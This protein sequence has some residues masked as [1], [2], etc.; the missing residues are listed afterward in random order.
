M[1]L[2]IPMS[3]TGERFRRAGHT[4]PKPLIE[5]EGKPIVQHVVESF[6]GV[7]DVVLVC[8]EAHLA[9]PAI[10][11]RT[12]LRD[13]VPH[14]RIASVAPHKLGPVHA[15]REACRT[16]GL[17]DPARPVI[18]N[19]CDFA[20]RWDFDHFVRFVRESACMGCI[21]CYTGFHPH[22]LRS[23]SYAY[24]DVERDASG[25]RT[26]WGR[27]IQEKRPFTLEPMEEYAS[28]GTYYFASAETMT[29]CMDA[30]VARDLRV[31]GE[32]YVSVAYTPL[33]EDSQPVAVYPLQ[34][35]MQ[36]G[37]PEDLD[38][39][40][41]WSRT[42]R[43]L[44]T[45]PLPHATHEGTTLIPMGGVG[46]RFAASTAV[47]KPLIDVAGVPM[48]ARALTDLP[49]APRQRF[50]L[51]PQL[52]SSEPLRAVLSEASRAPS[53]VTLAHGT[54]GQAPTCLAGLDGVDLDAPLTIGACDSGVLFDD[55]ALERALSDAKTDVWVYCARGYPGAARD[56]SAY[57]WVDADA[58]GRVRRV[59]V[60]EPLSNPKTDLLIIGTFTFRRA[61]DF[62]AA[63]ERMMAREARVRGEFYV[64][65]CIDDA[66]ALG[67][68][69]RT[70]EVDR[71]LCWGTPDDLAT[72]GYWQSCFHQWSSHPY[73]LQRDPRVP[74]DVV[75]R[76]EADWES[77]PPPI[78]RP[79][80]R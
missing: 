58:D 55:E 51:G 65:T 35:F 57:G 25:E 29:R 75:P 17:L 71:Y 2:I 21:P 24:V 59:S 79:R 41:D 6:P 80:D 63:A 19:Y 22:M 34:H 13:A 7:Q 16:P 68:V 62:V 27:G 44:E 31:A 56:P 4:T 33:F 36:W 70:F 69:C 66:V 12:R 28:S 61:R 73:S 48:V 52:A 40:L 53:F 37:T 10:A 47:P 20:W 1:Q 50:V 72:F 15:V 77:P 23:V 43:A 30:V 67:L 9:D 26:L 14:A 60:K 5:V 78:P 64:D 45:H 54:E 38:E 74:A 18:V 46:A 42:F 76:L 8:S 39:Y 49:R 32:Y 11:M 3:G